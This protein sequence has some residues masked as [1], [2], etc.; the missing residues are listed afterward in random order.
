MTETVGAANFY[1]N[2][3]DHFRQGSISFDQS[4][5][6]VLGSAVSLRCGR[7]KL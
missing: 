5:Y 6:R 2:H 1:V 4:D 7:V 3:E